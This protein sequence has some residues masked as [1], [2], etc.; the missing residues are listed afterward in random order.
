MLLVTNLVSVSLTVP[1]GGG[2]GG[3]SSALGMF[4]TKTGGAA[5]DLKCI[6]VL[7]L[8]YHGQ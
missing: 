1:W 8:N 7:F 4:I 2:G 6:L 5:L 3:V